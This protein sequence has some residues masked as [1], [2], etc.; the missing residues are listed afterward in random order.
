[1]TCTDASECLGRICR[2]ADKAKAELD[3]A[4][5]VLLVEDDKFEREIIS[6][7]LAQFHVA[8]DLAPNGE[9]A[10]ELVQ[11]RADLYKLLL[12]DL[13]LPGKKSGNDVLREADTLL[14]SDV[15]FVII[16]GDVNYLEPRK[17]PRRPVT[18]WRKPFE[19]KDAARI[20]M[21]AEPLGVHHAIKG[22]G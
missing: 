9:E 21:M 7:M 12:V 14:S 11:A 8:C 20:A 10:M 3:E 16:T 19:L 17:L 4:P 6:A 22:N 18:I 13:K 5:L 1:M 15:H 2:A